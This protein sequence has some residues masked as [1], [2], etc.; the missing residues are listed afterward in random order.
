[1]GKI[2]AFSTLGSIL[3]TFATGFFF[4]EWMGTRHVLLTTG[5]ILVVCAPIFGGSFVKKRTFLLLFVSLTLILW[6][7]YGKA[8][9]PP[10][11]GE[12]YYFKESN[13]YTISLKKDTADKEASLVTL[14]L[15]HL[16]HSRADLKNPFRLEY[17]YIRAFE[18]MLRWQVDE[19]K[20]FHSLFIGGGG[21]TLPRYVELQ[22]PNAKIEVVEIDPEVTRTAKTHMGIPPDTKIRT[23]NEDARWF[24]MNC[25]EKGRY[26]F[27][28]L[29][30]FS[31][32]SVPY[33]LTTK[34]FGLQLRLLLKPNGLLLTNVID[35]FSKGAF[36]PSYIRTLEEVFGKGY[37]NLISVSPFYD[38]L[39]ASNF[40]VVAGGQKIDLDDFVR[41]IRKL[42][43]QV[44]ISHVMPQGQLQQHLKDRYSVILTD[45]Y[46][47]VDNLTAP[48]FEELYGYQR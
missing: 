11:D 8:F 33:H 32:L 47:P 24:V 20:L 14:Y 16:N 27:I 19:K 46:V 12:T 3:G 5:I 48:L 31:D 40:V 7:F 17:R 9:Q 42:S 18:E 28:F 37:V 39:G 10:L 13:Y 6:V 41:E 30:A 43:N 21:Y 45:D 2:Y 26:D 4:I 35:D 23:F 29:D 38:S 22:Y 44:M 34:E 36:L 1:V 25:K 15:D